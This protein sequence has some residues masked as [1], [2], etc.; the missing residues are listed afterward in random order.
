MTVTLACY[1]VY[2]VLKEKLLDKVYDWKTFPTYSS[3]LSL[4]NCQ[5]KGKRLLKKT[6]KPHLPYRYSEPL[7]PALFLQTLGFG[8]FT[9]SLR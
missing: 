7:T 3:A 5:V 6:I 1:V 8:T 9:L 2:T 4:S